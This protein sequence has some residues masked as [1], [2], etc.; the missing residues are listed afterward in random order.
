MKRP[1]CDFDRFLIVMLFL[2]GVSMFTPARAG[3][4]EPGGVLYVHAQSG[5]NFRANPDINSPTLSVLEYGEGV[6]Y[7]GPMSENINHKDDWYID[8]WLHVEIEGVEGYVY[9]AYMSDLPIPVIFSDELSCTDASQLLRLYVEQEYGAPDSIDWF[10]K[11]ISDGTTLDKKIHY[12]DNGMI[13]MYREYEGGYNVELQIPDA[14]V[15]ECYNLIKGL[16]NE[17]D[18]LSYRIDDALFIK[19]ESNKIYEVKADGIVIREMPG[20]GTRIKIMESPITQCCAAV[21]NLQ[22]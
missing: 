5:L 21:E 15:M 11:R 19:K 3:V 17:C 1:I 7:C 13:I 14:N 10:S 9:G 6:Q 8:S 22:P 2:L 20:K 4:G 18:Q 16:Y 12:Y